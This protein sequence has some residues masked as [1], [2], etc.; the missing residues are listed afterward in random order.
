MALLTTL[1]NLIISSIKSMEYSVTTLSTQPHVFFFNPSNSWMF[2]Y[3]WGW[4][5]P[6]S[7]VRLSCVTPLNLPDHLSD[8]SL[9][10]ANCSLGRDGISCT[11][12][13]LHIGILSGHMCRSC[14]CC[15]KMIFICA[16]ALLCLTCFLIIIHHLQTLQHF[17]HLFHSYPW[18]LEGKI[19]IHM[20]QLG[21]N[22]L[23]SYSL[24]ND[25]IWVSG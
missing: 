10:N 15:H 4:L 25:Y 12:A 22:I 19:V 17:H 2:S 7:V 9:K 6:W 13:S 20:C 16:T 3:S 11:L 24:H 23:N 14:T 8:R 18:V 1:C 21:L 5:L